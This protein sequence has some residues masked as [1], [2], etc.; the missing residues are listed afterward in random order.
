M[1]VLNLVEQEDG[2]AILDIDLTEEEA[3]TVYEIGIYLLSNETDKEKII[4]EAL[5]YMI[6][7]GIIEEYEEHDEKY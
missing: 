1:E 2:S 5:L 7:L 4:N 6:V 3:Q